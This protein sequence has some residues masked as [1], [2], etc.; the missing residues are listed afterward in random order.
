MYEQRSEEYLHSERVIKPRIYRQEV[1]LN[2][3]TDTVLNAVDFD[4][5]DQPV[6]VRE[7]LRLRGHIRLAR[8]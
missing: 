3:G 6:S 5:V 7:R 1:N 8:I 4:R 2:N